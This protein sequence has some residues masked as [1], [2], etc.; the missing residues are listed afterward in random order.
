MKDL[1]GKRYRHFKGGEYEIVC[2]AFDSETQQEM[3]VY[4][5][6]YGDKKVWVRP[7]EMFF[8]EVERDGKV[9]K[10][11][12][13]IEGGK[14]QETIYRREL[15]IPNLF[16]KPYTYQTLTIVTYVTK[17]KGWFGKYNYDIKHSVP[18]CRKPFYDGE[19]HTNRILERHSSTE[20]ALAQEAIDRDK[21]ESLKRK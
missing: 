6:L 1:A 8:G 19:F 16:V 4:R 10:R 15:S 7:K 14:R 11:F 2:V 13:E 21:A 18:Y 3:V 20:R 5:A 9:L 17:R 12:S